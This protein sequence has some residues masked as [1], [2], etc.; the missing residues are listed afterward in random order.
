LGKKSCTISWR[1]R[2]VCADVGDGFAQRK[3]CP[4]R[5]DPDAKPQVAA[6]RV[7]AEGKTRARSRTIERRGSEPAI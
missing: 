4:H 6:M 7:S 5:D 3:S 1:I 2:F